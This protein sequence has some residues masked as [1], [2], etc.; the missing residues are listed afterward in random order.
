[1]IYRFYLIDSLEAEVPDEDSPTKLNLIK[2]P[3]MNETMSSTRWSLNFGALADAAISKI[4]ESPS[5]LEQ[6]PM[7]QMNN[8]RYS[9]KK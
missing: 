3:S 7:E 8:H 4:E 9:P 2:G 6:S 5:R 1:M